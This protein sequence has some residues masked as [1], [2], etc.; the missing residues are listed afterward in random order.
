MCCHLFCVPFF[1]ATP[2]D[3]HPNQKPESVDPNSIKPCL[4]GALILG[5]PTSD[6]PNAL[7]AEEEDPRENPD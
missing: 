1:S 2:M 3:P 7:R 4:S 6:T 5:S